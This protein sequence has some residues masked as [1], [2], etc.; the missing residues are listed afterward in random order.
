MDTEKS[1]FNERFAAFLDHFGLNPNSLAKALNDSAKVKYHNYKTGSARPNS[2]TL[3]LIASKYPVSIDWLVT[4]EG[5]ML[6]GQPVTP[7]V[8]QV[9]PLDRAIMQLEQ[10]IA[11][12]KNENR[13]LKAENEKVWRLTLPESVQKELD[14][15]RSGSYVTA[16]A[17][18]SNQQVHGYVRYAERK[19][20]VKPLNALLSEVMQTLQR[21]MPFDCPVE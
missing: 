1:S 19:A 11:I 9:M 14:F 4:G 17:I 12:L 5:E 21:T 13:M 3:Q 20:E 18:R 6:R 10:Q 7:V 2:D 16:D 8:E 15:L